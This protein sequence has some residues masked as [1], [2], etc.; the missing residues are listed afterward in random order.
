MNSSSKISFDLICTVERA[1]ESVLK[2]PVFYIVVD[3]VGEFVFC[4]FVS[5]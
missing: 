5:Y 3:D 1:K 2:L 4:L